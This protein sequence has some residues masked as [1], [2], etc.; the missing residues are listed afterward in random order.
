MCQAMLVGGPGQFAVAAFETA[1][2]LQK[3]TAP[4]N[5]IA[6]V[7]L[8]SLDSGEAAVIQLALNEN[9]QT[10]CI[11]EIVGRRMARLHGLTVTG[12]IGV[13]LRARRAGYNITMRDALDRMR[14]RGIWLSDRVVNFALAQAGEHPEIQGT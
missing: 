7:L 3:N 5:N 11:D 6:A 13:L 8:N 4:V 10:V 14:N 1:H 12:S 2:W 9:I